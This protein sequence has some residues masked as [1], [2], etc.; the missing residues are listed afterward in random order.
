MY[1]SLRLKY[2]E[3]TAIS[4]RAHPLSCTDFPPPVACLCLLL[5]S[6]R[7]QPQQLPIHEDGSPPF[8]W[9]YL[10]SLSALI[11]RAGHFLHASD[12][13][14]LAYARLCSL[15]H[16]TLRASPIKAG[17]AADPW[18]P[19]FLTFQ[20]SGSGMMYNDCLSHEFDAQHVVG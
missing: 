5:D 10:R 20:P 19:W 15:M 13:L 2:S 6:P 1:V 8:H 14:M 7:S 12:S 3:R 16:A 18:W 4:R 11:G 9:L 17:R